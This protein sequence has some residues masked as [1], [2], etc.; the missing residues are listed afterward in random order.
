MKTEVQKI[1][2]QNPR[3]ISEIHLDMDLTIKPDTEANREILKNIGINCP[4]ALSLHPDIKQ[5]VS[6]NFSPSL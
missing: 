5:V 3:R 6:F 1:M 2:V 4:V